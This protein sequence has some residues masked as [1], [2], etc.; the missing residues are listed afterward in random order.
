MSLA[1]DTSA[2]PSASAATGTANAA[3]HAA[4]FVHSCDDRTI[5]QVP[6]IGSFTSTVIGAALW[7]RSVI[8][9]SSS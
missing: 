9:Y 1:R 7:L 5:F 6:P 8:S 2:P 3:A 4:V